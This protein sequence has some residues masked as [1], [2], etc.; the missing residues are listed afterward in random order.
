MT[1]AYAKNVY[2][3]PNNP[4]SNK[5]Y[6]MMIESPIT[7]TPVGAYCSGAVDI[8]Q[9]SSSSGTVDLLSAN[10][11]NESSSVNVTFGIGSPTFL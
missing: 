11:S 2:T 5:N 1:V 9:N 3:Y 6:W 4:D 8:Y 7:V 10:S